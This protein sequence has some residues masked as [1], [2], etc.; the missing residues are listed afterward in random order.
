MA[1]R[2]RHGRVGGAD[3]CVVSEFDAEWQPAGCALVDCRLCEDRREVVHVRR[4]TSA[5]SPE[6]AAKVLLVRQHVSDGHLPG[7]SDAWQNRREQRRLRL[8]LIEQRRE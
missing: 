2:D 7:C 1:E 5:G 3:D 4:V 6:R 8:P